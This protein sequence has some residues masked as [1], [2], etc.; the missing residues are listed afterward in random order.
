MNFDRIAPH[1]RIDRRV[2][3]VPENLEAQFVAILLRG[4]NHVRHGN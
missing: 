2:E 4:H 1:D 3:K